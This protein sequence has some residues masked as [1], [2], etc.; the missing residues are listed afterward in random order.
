MRISNGVNINFWKIST[1]VLAGLLVSGLVATFVFF[2][3][4]GKLEVSSEQLLGSAGP[5][6]A[7]PVLAEEIYPLFFC[8]CCGNPLDKNNICCPMAKERIDYID[9]LVAQNLSEKEIIL[10]YV[11]KYG[12]NSFVDENKQKEFREKLI[13][14]APAER[15]KIVITPE[16]YDFGD[17]SQK[18]GNV[19][20]YF[21]LKNEGKK[22]LVIDRM[23]TSCGCTFVAIVS[24]S[25]ESPYFT[26]PGHGY[27]NPKWDGAIIPAGQ[28]AQLKVMYD[29]NVHQDFR[30]F[31]I[32][33]IYV[34]SNDP[35]DFEKKVQVE[36]N[37]VD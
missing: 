22:D 25:Q 37:Q 29:P 36:L 9:S 6:L 8:P 15:P 12:L 32:R 5:L 30:G 18:G 13:A 17:V 23:D 3:K 33:E 34:Y 11:K 2:S 19:F 26:M 10:A 20:T 7:E 14:T 21:E 28:T 31:A 24:E 27:E 4:S 1:L 35:I 16:T